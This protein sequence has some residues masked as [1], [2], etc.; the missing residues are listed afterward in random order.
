M[1]A[2]ARAHQGRNLARVRESLEGLPRWLLSHFP[3]PHLRLTTSVFPNRALLGSNDL[4]ALYNSLLAQNL[5]RIV[6]LYSV[7]E[8]E[9]VSKAVG[10][11]S[12]QA[13][14]VTTFLLDSALWNLWRRTHFSAFASKFRLYST[15]LLFNIQ[16]VPCLQRVTMSSII[17]QIILNDPQQRSSTK[18]LNKVSSTEFSTKASLLI[19]DGHR[20]M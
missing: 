9:Y 17:A 13:Q 10:R 7:V 6:E 2:I 11:H 14:C 15:S 18:I 20:Q 12:V 16:H 8:A 3:H 4:A 1:R 5:L 19:F